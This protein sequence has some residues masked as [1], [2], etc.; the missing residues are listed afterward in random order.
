MN[1][2]G[3]CNGHGSVAGVMMKGLQALVG[4]FR[5]GAIRDMLRLYANTF[6]F[7]TPL[8]KED[9]R[10]AVYLLRYLAWLV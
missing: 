3:I 4:D 6:D 1:G 7:P 8:G 10:L 9:K 5:Q 2:S